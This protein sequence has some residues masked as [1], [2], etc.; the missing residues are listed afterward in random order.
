[1]TQQE[2]I[3]A[4]LAEFGAEVSVRVKPNQITFD[5]ENFVGLS[6][7]PEHINFNKTE[8]KNTV[9]HLKSQ[10]TTKERD[11]A[12]TSQEGKGSDA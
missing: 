11:T 5:H 12:H 2:F 1:M 8:V 4:V 7:F 9:A 6:V 3:D 10:W